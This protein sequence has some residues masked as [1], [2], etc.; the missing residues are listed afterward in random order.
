MA[1]LR[2]SCPKCSSR[3][4]HTR[5]PKNGREELLAAIGLKRFYWCRNCNW[6]F[7][8]AVFRRPARFLPR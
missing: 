3:D 7:S 8:A 1:W 4:V 2:V 5:A 6:P